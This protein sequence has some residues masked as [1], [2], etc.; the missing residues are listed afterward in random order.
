MPEFQFA[1]NLLRCFVARLLGAGSAKVVSI[2]LNERRRLCHACDLSQTSIEESGIDEL[3]KLGLP[4]KPL[5]SGSVADLAMDFAPP[6][7][8]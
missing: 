6:V 1:N 2:D 7:E 3:R 4:K 5:A 8:Y